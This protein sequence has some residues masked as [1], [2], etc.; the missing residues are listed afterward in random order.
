MFVEFFKLGNITFWT[1]L[2]LGHT[3][4]QTYN[5]HNAIWWEHINTREVMMRDDFI[6][7]FGS[8]IWIKNISKGVGACTKPW[9]FQFNLGL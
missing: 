9:L 4:K 3:T 6:Q 5:K 7:L 1:Q 8:H 2:N